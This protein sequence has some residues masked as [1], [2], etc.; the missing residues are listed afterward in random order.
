MTPLRVFAIKSMIIA[1]STS[2]MTTAMSARYGVGALSA[3]TQIAHLAL[4]AI[5]DKAGT[6]I[7]TLTEES[8][9]LGISDLSQSSNG[10]PDA[11]IVA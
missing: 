11:T 10:L 6:S 3:R 5:W 9:Q 2:V 8:R 7:R 1:K 4:S